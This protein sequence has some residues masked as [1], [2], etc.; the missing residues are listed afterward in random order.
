MK[1]EDKREVV[2]DLQQRLL[3][4][5]VAILTRFSGLNVGRMTQLRRD[6]RKA[7]VEYRIIKNTL[8]RLAI[9]GSPQEILSPHLEGPLAVAWSEKDPVGPAKILAKYS[10]DFP[11][12]QILVAAS[13]GR[14]WDAKAI[15][16]WVNLPSL[17]ELRAKILGMIQAP[18]TGLVRLF[19]TPGTQMAQVLK[20]R[21][22]QQS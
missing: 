5:K 16:G 17:E 8:F 1:R 11:Q 3:R 19:N 9:Q 7:G 13:D 21:S 18:A 2:S 15:Q 12:L 4:A 22:E 14:L 6:L 20:A 10:K